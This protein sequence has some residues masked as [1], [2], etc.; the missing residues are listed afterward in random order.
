M[1]VPKDECTPEAM[2]LNRVAKKIKLIL[3]VV[4]AAEMWH[5]RAIPQAD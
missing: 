1:A 2:P 3:L 4:V 5:W